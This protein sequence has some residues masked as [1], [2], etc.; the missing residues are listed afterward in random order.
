[1]ENTKKIIR[2]L[3]IFGTQFNFYSDKKKIYYTTLGGILT[4]ITVSTCLIIFFFFVR[5]DINRIYPDKLFISD[6]P[7][8]ENKII[9]KDEKLFMPWRIINKNNNNFLYNNE[10]I[11]PIVTYYYFEKNFMNETIQKSKIINYKLCSDMM[12][13]NSPGID[14]LRVRLNELYCLDST[15]IELFA[16]SMGSYSNY[17]NID[18]Y[19]NKNQT[20]YISN[21]MEI[22]I[23][24]PEILFEPL[25]LKSP[26]NINY[27]KYSY[28]VNI[29]SKKVNKIFFQK[30]ILSD[31]KGWFKKFINEYS[32][33]TTKK[34]IENTYFSL[35]DDN[36]YSISINIELNNKKYIRSYKKIYSIISEGTPIISILFMILKRIS[37]IIKTTEENQKLVE[38]LFENLKI[39]KNKFK[40]A[41]NKKINDINNKNKKSVPNLIE[42]GNHKTK[43]TRAFSRFRQ[44]DDV[45][46]NDNN[47]RRN[48]IG[49]KIGMSSTNLKKHQKNDNISFLKNNDNSNSI[50]LNFFSKKNEHINQLTD[51]DDVKVK[52]KFISDIPHSFCREGNLPNCLDDSHAKNNVII[53]N[54]DIKYVP[55]KLFPYRYYIF[56]I[57][58]KSIDGYKNKFCLPKKFVKVNLFLGQLLDI[59]TYLILQKE[60]HA[61]KNKCLTKEEVNIIERKNK[62][63][64]GSPIFIR[65]VNECIENERFDILYSMK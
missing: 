55:K 25:N 27:K 44:N 26:M 20:N 12:M 65:K 17:I 49:N 47:C 42:Y 28:N 32:C 4:V 56:L 22:E 62:I 14:S 38:L 37:I 57:F 53:S 6:I 13:A 9:L 48:T 11:N 40:K 16:S 18:F 29:Y 35:E 36:I 21:L 60:F 1:M 45:S 59:S 15:D 10:L 58:F 50:I 19:I 24:F 39:K 33:W 7:Q 46:N 8:K 54:N 23:Y 30:N 2:F 43:Q 41:L 51:L 5:D 63:N 52:Y 34:I 3:D 64:I 61:L 31:D